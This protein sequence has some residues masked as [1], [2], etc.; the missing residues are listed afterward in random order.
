MIASN[1]LHARKNA[2]AHL[3]MEDFERICSSSRRAILSKYK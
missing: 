1:T 2:A 3:A